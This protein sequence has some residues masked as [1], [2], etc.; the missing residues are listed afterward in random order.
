MHGQMSFLTRRWTRANLAGTAG[1]QYRVEVREVVEVID[2]DYYEPEE[3]LYHGVT[4][5]S[6]LE[7]ALGALATMSRLA[8]AYQTP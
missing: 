3:V 8:M 2:P 7:E 5:A 4:V 6:S 1:G